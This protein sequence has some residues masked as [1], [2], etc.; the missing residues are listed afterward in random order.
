MDA[1]SKPGGPRKLKVE[2]QL[3]PGTQL[4][5]ESGLKAKVQSQCNEVLKNK[6]VDVPTTVVEVQTRRM[7]S[8]DAEMLVQVNALP[9][10]P[11]VI[12]RF[13]DS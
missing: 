13:K 7:D 9:P 6:K 3:K 5:N 11:D 4:T 1:A 12:L 8:L 2:V 10:Q